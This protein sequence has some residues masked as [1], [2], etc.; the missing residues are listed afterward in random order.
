MSI[1]KALKI[2]KQFT[3]EQNQFLKEARDILLP[4]L[5][6]GAIDI[7]RAQEESLAI[8]AEPKLH[9]SLKK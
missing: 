8:A 1:R 9:Y 4:R 7:D 5:M 3:I 2:R 6:V